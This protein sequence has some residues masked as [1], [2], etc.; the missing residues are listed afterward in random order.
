M[1]YVPPSLAAHFRGEEITTAL[2]WQI[3]KADGTVI[4]GTDHDTD[5]E[6]ED[7]DDILTGVYSSSSNISASQIKTNSDGSVDNMEVE[8]ALPKP[9]EHRIDVSIVD[10]EAGN[11]SRAPVYVF[12]VNWRRPRDGIMLIKRGYLG[13]IQRTSDYQYRTELR[14]L[15]QLLAQNIMRS[16][17]ERCQVL[18]FGDHECGFN[19]ARATLTGTVTG[20]TSRRRFD[21]TLNNGTP[22]TAVAGDFR[23]GELRF[24]SGAN[25]GFVRSVK[26]DDAA[27]TLGQFST[28]ENF[29]YTVTTGATFEVSFGCDR[30]VTSCKRFGRL[31]HG[32]RGYGLYIPGINAIMAGPDTSEEGRGTNYKD[33]VQRI[34]DQ[35]V[36]FAIEEQEEEDE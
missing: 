36:Q 2:C 32:F 4:R 21:T 12:V 7:P 3:E 8:G 23:N 5:I 6:V 26:L 18:R 10:I 31:K 13:E 11:L 17:S 34:A 15:T 27:G 35:I 30:L 29:P 16:Y 1:K 19:L 28:W 33:L 25:A 9:D 22:V 14:G 24:T 20:V